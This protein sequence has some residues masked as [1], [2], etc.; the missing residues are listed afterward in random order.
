[1]STK[2]CL[3]FIRFGF[4]HLIFIGAFSTGCCY[5]QTNDANRTSLE[6][7]PNAFADL[8]NSTQLT[9]EDEK[10][11]DRKLMEEWTKMF[12]S[13]GRVPQQ[14]KQMLIF[15]G[16]FSELQFVCHPYMYKKSLGHF[17]CRRIDD[18]G[19]G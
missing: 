4:V 18:G 1:M 6:S 17:K 9:L 13:M 19:S 8:N 5:Q 16:L 10:E 7:T 15:P 12:F 3:S 2:A 11:N 14:G